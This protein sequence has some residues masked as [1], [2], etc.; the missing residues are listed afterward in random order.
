M[1]ELIA[2]GTTTSAW[3][4]FTVSTA[5]PVT[6]FLKTTTGTDGPM[7]YGPAFEVAHKTPDG[8][9]VVLYEINANN[10]TERGLLYAPGTYGVRRLATSTPAGIDAEGNT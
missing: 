8:D 1:A 2:V 6:L 9:Y 5:N 3:V 4:D 7:P 10:A